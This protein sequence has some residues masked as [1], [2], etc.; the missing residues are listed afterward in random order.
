MTTAVN[1]STVSTPNEAAVAAASPITTSPA[2]KRTPSFY[3]E[4][5]AQRRSLSLRIE[6]LESRYN[7]SCTAVGRAAEAIIP[8]RIRV[9]S[10][11]QNKM[12]DEEKAEFAEIV[13]LYEPLAAIDAEDRREHLRRK[14]AE[15]AAPTAKVTPTAASVAQATSPTTQA[16]AATPP[17]K[18]LF[19]GTVIQSALVASTVAKAGQYLCYLHTAIV[20][21]GKNKQAQAQSS[22]F[23]LDHVNNVLGNYFGSKVKEVVLLPEHTLGGF[24]AETG[25][26]A[27]ALL[28]SVLANRVIDNTSFAPFLPHA[29]QPYESS[30]KR[31]AKVTSAVALCTLASCAPTWLAGAVVGGTACSLFRAAHVM[32]SWIAR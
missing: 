23:S 25:C 4:V 14:A 19:T 13:R 32:S 28:V 20:A 10:Q 8:G 29:L 31:V 2:R 21:W 17:P 30:M 26:L 27:S 24:V 22:W 11:Q 15:E 12:S 3:A 7:I 1:S 9:L 6:T 18:S 5:D 16:P